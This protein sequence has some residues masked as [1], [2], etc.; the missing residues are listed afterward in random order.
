MTTNILLEATPRTRAGAPVTVRMA[1]KAA[2]PEGTYLDGKQ[3][4]PLISKRPT[5]GVDLMDEEG[6]LKPSET[7][8]GN[9]EFR[10]SEVFENEEWS[11]YVWNNAPAKIWIGE[12]GQ[13]FSEYICI[14]TGAVSALS[15]DNVTASLE[16]IGPD[17]ALDADFLTA[18]YAGTGGAEGTKDMEGN[19]KPWCS[20]YASNVD[21]VLVDQVYWVFQVHGYGPILDIPQVYERAEA[22]DPAKMKASVSTYA[23]LIAVPLQPAEWAVCLPLGMFRLGGA[24]RYKI[25]A[26]AKGAKNGSFT[27]MDLA[28][29]VPHLLQKAGIAADK[30]GDFSDFAGVAWN[31]YIDSQVKAGELVRDALAQGGGVLLSDGNGEWFGTDFYKHGNAV[32]LNADRSTSPLVRPGSIK[33]LTVADPV[34]KVE[35]GYNRCWAV[36]DT[37]EVSPALDEALNAAV[38]GAQA[39]VGAVADLQEQVDNF[40]GV[41]LYPIIEQID[42]MAAIGVQAITANDMA[43]RAY[44]DEA[45]AQVDSLRHDVLSDGESYAEAIDILTTRTNDNQTA[46]ANEATLRTN[47]DSALATSIS[48][49]GAKA[50]QNAAAITAEQTAR[51][52]GDSALSQTISQVQASVGATNAA[53]SAEQTARASAIAAETSARN[54]AI[55]SLNSSLTAAIVSEQNTRVTKDNALTDSINQLNAVVNDAHARITTEQNARVSADNANASSIQTVQSNLNGTNNSLA[56][57]QQS[58]TTTTNRV[59]S[60]EAQY[61]LSVQAGNTVVGIKALASSAG[62]SQLVFQAGAMAFRNGSGGADTLMEL[63]NGQVR[64]RSAMIGDATI[65]NAHIQKLT[66]GPNEVAYDSITRVHYA[67]RGALMYGNNAYQT[68]I[69]YTLYSPNDCDLIVLLKGNQGFPSGD[70]RWESRIYCDGIEL[71][72]A[73]GAKTADTY[74]LIGRLRVGAGNHTVSCGWFGESTAV[75]LASQRMIVLERI[76]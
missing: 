45:F 57:V 53:L 2:G 75:R 51:A 50:D 43:A 44:R 15:R 72:G 24:P 48:T 10:L 55:S 6:N 68:S 60:V 62:T 21:P 42:E 5:I 76:R 27:P 37:D 30:I 32:P 54:Q 28:T 14:H 58:L 11:T 34:Y 20:G 63:V 8:R 67:D 69:S 7:R 49:V 70:R 38:D 16:L 71:D 65:N 29:I 23:E 31:V 36:H 39:V 12:I 52:N 35:I 26:D 47:A 22:L 9:I 59:G 33:Q 73:G 19:V 46:I 4:L 3:W 41:N 56:L 25:T 40:T 13:P 64:I 66:I 18:T 1:H 17:A 74:T 61:G